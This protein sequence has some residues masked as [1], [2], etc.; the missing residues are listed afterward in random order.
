MPEFSRGSESFDTVAV[1]A[2]WLSGLLEAAP[3]ESVD[4]PNL[5]PDTRLVA[6]RVLERP[7]ARLAAHIDAV[8]GVGSG[9]LADDARAYATKHGKRFVPVEPAL[10]GGLSKGKRTRPCGFVLG[11][12]ADATREGNASLVE[13]WLELDPARFTVELCERA[14]ALRRFIV[15]QRLS[16]VTDALAFPEP[17]DQEC[18]SNPVVVVVPE[19]TSDAKAE[20]AR[21]E[22]ECLLARAREDHPSS[23]VWLL[24][25]FE[26]LARHRQTLEIPR[27]ASYARELPPNICRGRLLDGAKHVYTVNS[28]FGFEA[29][30]RGVPVTVLG[31]PFY[32]GWGL[33]TD[34]DPTCKRGA[35]RSLDELVA[36]ALILAPVYVDPVTECRTSPEALLAYLALQRRRYLENR[37]HF[38]CVG[39][40]FWKRA[41]LRRYLESPENHIEFVRDA[42]ALQAM[43]LADDTRLVVWASRPHETVRRLAEDRKLTLLRVEDGFLRSVGLGS[44]WAA[45]GSLVFD[46]L[47]IYYDPSRP[48]RLER[49]LAE[50]DFTD[51]D[52]TAAEGL[53]Q[54]ILSLRISKYNTHGDRNF[55][56]GAK[57]GQPVV[58]VPGQVADDASVRLG[59][60]TVGGVRELL[61]AVR[62]LEPDAH[63][64]YKPHPDVLSGNR[65]GLVDEGRGIWF[66]ELVLDVPIARCLDAVDRVHTMSSL[67]G[68]EALL[69][70]IPVVCHGK[71]FYSGWGLTRDLYPSERRDR[72]LT[73]PMLV[74]AVLLRYP[75]YYHFPTGSFCSAAQ[76][77]SA[78]ARSQRTQVPRKRRPKLLR[79]LDS[80]LQL[81]KDIS[82]AG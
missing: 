52:L 59:G 78:I 51:A 31:R 47:G 43:R 33:T 72:A 39:F 2:P 40:S 41:I 81:A 24:R 68:F 60:A 49:I 29:L 7:T 15:E 37:G 35:T 82:H 22:L 27:T 4:T 9:P 70:K 1:F 50:A 11:P 53:R 69:R 19:L 12:S 76:M 16:R 63:V 80:L 44:D 21:A 6:R 74:A 32:A 25:D 61:M 71:P 26:P 10:F 58:L 20:E 56:P 5:P 67:V 75:R 64:V 8:I 28:P 3:K 17:L 54:T 42:R 73:L 57:P 66:D 34:L 38:V 48:S 14:A 77:A 79:R 45:P 23:P 55:V 65:K 18:V 13:A 62:E 46:D 30:L 36:A